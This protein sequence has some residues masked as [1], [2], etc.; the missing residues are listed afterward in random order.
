MEMCAGDA[1]TW[2]CR[3]LGLVPVPVG[4]DRDVYYRYI[5]SYFSLSLV[6]VLEIS[7]PSASCPPL[8][9]KWN[10]FLLLVLAADE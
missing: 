5:V 2:S 1:H 8:R 9:E 6:R 4:R 10:G 7:R 3:E